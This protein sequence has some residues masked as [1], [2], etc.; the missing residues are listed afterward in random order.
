MDCKTWQPI[1]TAPKAEFMEPNHL[2]LVCDA[3]VHPD[4]FSSE[5]TMAFWADGG[6][7]DLPEPG[8]YDWNSPGGSCGEWELIKPTHWMPLPE[9]PTA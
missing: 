2:I 4:D 6:S 7:W 5:I 8:W 3:D 9:P 1:E